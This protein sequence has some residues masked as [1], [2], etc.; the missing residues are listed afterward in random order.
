M[1]AKTTEL[2]TQQEYQ[3]YTKSNYDKEYDDNVV[4]SATERVL[5]LLSENGVDVHILNENEITELIRQQSKFVTFSKSKQEFDET[6]NLAVKHNGIIV[7]DIANTNVEIVELSKHHFNSINKIDEAKQW[8]KQNLTTSKGNEELPKMIDGTEYE[9][10]NQ[11][12]NKFLSNSATSK[13]S[14]LDIHLSVLVGLKDIIAKSIDVEI[15]PDYKKGDDKVRRI[16]NG[17]NERKLIHR[18]YGSIR[19]DGKL[20]RVKTTMQEFKGSE[21]NKPHSYEVTKI[22]LLEEFKLNNA[23]DNTMQADYKLKFSNSIS[24]AKLLKGV[25]KSYEKGKKLL[26]YAHLLE[27]IKSK[28]GEICG[29]TSGNTIYLT[30][31]GINPETPIHEYAHLWCKVMEITQ[32]ELWTDVIVPYIKGSPVWNEV[33]ADKRY[34]KIHSDDSRMA[35][36]VIARLSGRIGAQKQIMYA[37]EV[38]KEPNERYRGIKATLFNNMRKALQKFWTMVKNH[39]FKNFKKQKYSIE[40]ECIANMV[41]DDLISGEVVNKETLEIIDVERIK[42]LCENDDEANILKRIDDIEF[43]FKQDYCNNFK[44]LDFKELKSKIKITEFAEYIGYKLRKDK[45]THKHLIY[46]H[47]S[48]EKICIY[49]NPDGKPQIYMTIGGL[50]ADKG[51]IISFVKN[52]I[53]N[54]IINKPINGTSP[55]EKVNILLHEYLNIPF[56]DRKVYNSLDEYIQKSKQ[57]LFISDYQPYT[58]NITIKAVEYMSTRGLDS[59]DFLIY[60]FRGSVVGTNTAKIEADINKIPNNQVAFPLYDKNE[61]MVGV[62]LVSENYKSFLKGSRKSVGVW[63]SNIPEKINNIV[64]CEAPLDA[65]SYHKLQGDRNTLYFATCG[66][67]TDG[68]L[69]AIKSIIENN[70]NV[71]A[72]NYTITLAN[73]NDAAGAMF[74]LNYIL[75]TLD[76]KGNTNIHFNNTKDGR[77]D[78]MISLSLA[79]TNNLL[80]LYDNLPK[81]DINLEIKAKDGGVNILYSKDIKT[82]SALNDLLLTSKPQNIKIDVP[83]TKDYNEDLKTLQH[84]NS[85]SSDKYSYQDVKHNSFLFTDD[86]SKFHKEKKKHRGIKF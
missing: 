70:K 72:A 83:I 69:D 46:E 33:L 61:K 60:P 50:N 42:S 63:H 74:N 58:G 26:N 24:L 16:E 82:I 54:G 10:S 13:S 43:Q 14:N 55:F 48:G 30:Q 78:L 21:K 19:I 2:R 12:I 36:E 49:N 39:I 11:A 68:Q 5:S 56:E 47:S 27:E 9:I 31:D 40:E 85:L 77:C 25:E 1:E 17:Y 8:A 37:K 80:K 7:T 67:V 51:D 52:K 59:N 71:L 4:Q 15:H 38:I 65:I 34:S 28:S 57:N 62:Q 81:E 18:L 41:N 6:L 76:E 86:I 44:Q 53:D 20:Y 3:L 23:T 84:I 22:E 75:S 66:N 45:T 73:D 29:F 32:H 79:D 35:S 64:I